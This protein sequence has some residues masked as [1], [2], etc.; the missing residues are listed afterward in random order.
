MVGPDKGY[1][2]RDQGSAHP[3]RPAREPVAV[4]EQRLGAAAEAPS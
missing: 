3:R 1:R 2:L 4:P